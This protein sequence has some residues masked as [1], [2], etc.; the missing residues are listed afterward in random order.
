MDS[1]SSES[2]E[3]DSWID[4]YLSLDGNEFLCEVDTDYIQ[5]SFN[6]YGLREIVSDFKHA[7]KTILDH[8]DTTASDSDDPDFNNARVLY[9]LIHQR[10]IL[11]R[12]GLDKMVSPSVCFFFFLFCWSILYT[13][14]THQKQAKE[15]APIFVAGASNCC[16]GMPPLTRVVPL[17][18]CLLCCSFANTAR[19]ILVC[20][21]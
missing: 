21:Q 17:P 18:L 13:S 5:D 7:L 10:Y 3:K 11:S 9:G 2:D 16:V 4:R 14:T 12:R 19:V 1:L 6:L 15:S 20:V 8:Y